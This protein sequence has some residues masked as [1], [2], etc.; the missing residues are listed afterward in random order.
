MGWSCLQ[1]KMYLKLISCEILYREICA[2]LARALHQVD[3]EF[4]PKGLHDIGGKQMCERI[5]AAVDQVD[6]SRYDAVILGYGFC[7]TGLAGLTARSIPVVLPRGH[8]CITL[9]LGSRHRYL[10]YFENNPDTFYK[11]T[12][13]IERGAGL[14]Q[15]GGDSFREKFGIA[16]T[17]EEMAGRYGEDNAKY[18]WEQLGGYTKNYGKLTY[19]ETGVEP[20]D[21]F[22][23]QTREEAAERGLEF[24]KLRGDLG[25]LNRLVSGEWDQEDFLAVA[26]GHRIVARYDDSIMGTEKVT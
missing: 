19:I 4:L 7:G 1:I 13:W 6:G 22:E 24:E 23:R 12:G 10:R 20:D 15:L 21:R 3:A 2:C 8:D 5:Q 9:F 14:D 17:Y 18:L 25:L 11:T 26:P 16:Q